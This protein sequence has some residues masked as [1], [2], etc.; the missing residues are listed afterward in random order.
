M[1]RETRPVRRGWR[2]GAETPEQARVLRRS[3]GDQYQGYLFTKP[4]PLEGIK[5]H[6]RGRDNIAEENELETG[7]SDARH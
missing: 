7:S 4:L 1:S 3:H 2:K 6:R 5:M